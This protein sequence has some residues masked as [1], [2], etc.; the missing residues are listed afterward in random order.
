VRSR[1]G[2]PRPTKAVGPILASIVTLI[3]WAAVA[4]NSG[5]G[6]VQALGSLLAGFVVLGLGGPALATARLS[7]SVVSNPT[8]TTVGLP[9]SIELRANRPLRVQP[10]RPPGPSVVAGSGIMHVELVPSRR[11]RVGEVALLIGSA[12]PFGILWWHKRVV[13]ALARELWV[14]PVAGPPDPALLGGATSGAHLDRHRPRDARIGEPRGVR[15]YEGGDSRRLVHWP[16]TA[17]RGELMVREAERA[18]SAV[19]TVRVSLPDDGPA[20]DAVAE[21]ALGTVLVLL[22]RSSPV[23]LATIERDGARVEAV[24][25]PGDAGRRLARAVASSAERR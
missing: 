5:S 10:V 23:M 17:H 1:G 19:P 6:W 3:G 18:E 11:G 16:A 4:H 22:A 9:V 21:R 2:W 25:A 8:D 15:P 20:G 7:V 12:A 24:Y 14:A 13:V